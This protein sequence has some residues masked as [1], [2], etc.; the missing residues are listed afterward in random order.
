MWVVEITK[1]TSGPQKWDDGPNDTKY[2]YSE[3]THEVFDS[4]VK[5]NNKFESIKYFENIRMYHCIEIKS[6]S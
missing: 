5:A 2:L 3:T 1:L 4:E 6:K